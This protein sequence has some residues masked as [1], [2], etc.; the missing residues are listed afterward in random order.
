MAAL[1]SLGKATHQIAPDPLR[2]TEVSQ[3]F[4]AMNPAAVGADSKDAIDG[5]VD[6]LHRCAPEGSARYPGERTL[7]IR[8]ENQRLG[9]PVDEP[10]WAEIEGLTC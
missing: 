7:Q 2:E 9:L 8:A 5:I 4:V 6:S 10:V 1:L 3:V